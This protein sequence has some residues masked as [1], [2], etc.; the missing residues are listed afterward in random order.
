MELRSNRFFG[1]EIECKGVTQQAACAAITAAGVQ[2]RIEN[3]GHSTP[4][5][6]K[7]V[8][9]ASVYAGFEIVSP[10]LSGNEGLEQ[11]RKVAAALNGIGASVERDCGFHVH[12]DASG[13]NAPTLYNLVHRYFQHEA[14]IDS[15]M[16]RSRRSSNNRYCRSTGELLR[17][18][19]RPEAGMQI[20]DFVQNLDSRDDRYFKVNIAAFLRHGTI[21]FRQH[22]G[23]T[24]ANKM[25]PWI[26][27][28]VNF[29]ET[30][31][32]AVSSSPN[33]TGITIP[34]EPPHIART[35]PRSPERKFHA[36]ARA[37]VR[38][39]RDNYIT[40]EALAEVLGCV[41]DSVPSY[42]S[43]F[44]DAHPNFGV[45]SRRG[46]GY[47]LDLATHDDRAVFMEYLGI[48][49]GTL[50]EELTSGT[51]VIYSVVYPTSPRSHFEGLSPDVVSYFQERAVELAS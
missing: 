6:W 39:S 42:I 27:F 31:F 32:V 16:P 25:I 2:C 49:Y 26:I 11:V 7:I 34:T 43:R 33:P 18:I 14:E 23:T 10:K 45:K 17:M 40:V 47:Y 8:S 24:M 38:T 12:V 4:S 50:W 28:C 37:L 41:P 36:L 5:M 1:I 30:S 15:F 20:R 35:S 48:P 13:L 44:R 19:R 51:A 3:Y 46:R 9:D 21:E 29:V 22:S